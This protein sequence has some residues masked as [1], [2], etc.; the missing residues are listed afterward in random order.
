MLWLI[1]TGM[2]VHMH[3]NTRSLLTKKVILGKVS[4]LISSQGEYYVADVHF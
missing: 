4:Y 3:I 1:A 2:S